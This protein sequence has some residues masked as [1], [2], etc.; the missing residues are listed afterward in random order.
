[1]SLEKELQKEWPTKGHNGIIGK[2]TLHSIV[3][4][5]ERE[6]L[7][8]LLSQIMINA[9]KNETDSEKRDDFYDR[10]KPVLVG[11]LGRRQAIFK[12]LSSSVQ[13]LVVEKIF[14]KQ[15]GEKFVQEQ[16]LR[17][18]NISMESLLTSSMFLFNPQ[19]GL[20]DA[21]DQDL[22]V[23]DF[24]DLVW[25]MAAGFANQNIPA[26]QALEIVPNPSSNIK[27]HRFSQIVS[28]TGQQALDILSGKASN[29]TG[30]IRSI[31]ATSTSSSSSTSTSTS[32]ESTNLWEKTKTN[33]LEN[34]RKMVDTSLEKMADQDESAANIAFKEGIQKFFQDLVVNNFSRVEKTRPIAT[35]SPEKISDLVAQEANALKTEERQRGNPHC[36]I[37]N[38]VTLVDTL[39]TS[40]ISEKTSPKKYLEQQ[41]FFKAEIPLTGNRTFFT[42]I[43]DWFAGRS[44]EQSA[45][46]GIVN[47]LPDKTLAKADKSALRKYIQ[48]NKPT[49]IIM[50]LGKVVGFK[51]EKKGANN[52]LEKID[53][54]STENASL[55]NFFNLINTTKT[56]LDKN[57]RSEIL[58]KIKTA[59]NT[60]PDKIKAYEE[61]RL[62]TIKS[63]MQG[64]E[65]LN[66]I[67]QPE[68]FLR[69]FQNPS[70]FKFDLIKPL[71]D[72]SDTAYEK[73][74]KLFVDVLRQ[75]F[76]HAC[77]QPPVPNSL[78]IM[79]FG[80]ITEKT[81]AAS[82]LLVSKPWLDSQEVLKA[83]GLVFS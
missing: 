9:L 48:S 53:D 10:E 18:L 26:T 56:G 77:K 15:E 17:K 5:K 8:N 35:L 40:T 2:N 58:E 47:S 74:K 37:D 23:G 66:P 59:S 43:L 83:S 72:P 71:L 64:L 31:S 63:L 70:V 36:Y 80:Q 6:I 16:I 62:R 7:K 4:D 52:T 28:E 34:I 65:K 49:Q 39:N 50:N 30:F 46:L 68:E 78:V 69:H 1:M 19:N 14:T 54:I 44:A 12:D 82:A 75:G 29:F 61:S 73:E 3:Q 67:Q 51:I 33:T 81:M 55:Q 57:N 38:I 76:Y 60:C 25:T 11:M 20:L 45:L 22:W 79:F 41:E 42:K 24:D 13:S 21:S 32:T 27:T